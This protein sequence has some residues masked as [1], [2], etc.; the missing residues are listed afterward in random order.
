M[1]RLL[2]PV[3]R[4]FAVLL[5]SGLAIGAAVFS[6]QASSP[7]SSDACTVEQ[8]ALRTADGVLLD[9]LL[10]RPVATPR[11]SAILLVHGFGGNFYEA[12]FPLFGQTAREQGYTTLALNM[13]DHDAG[14]KV[15]S[16]IDNEIDIAAGLAY[17]RKLGYSRFVLLGQS[18]GTNRVLYFQAA[19]KDPTIAATILV[20]GPGN[21]FE[22]N[23]W[24]FGRKKAQASVDEALALQAAGRERDLML[25]DLGP[26]GK[27]L[28]TARYLLSLRGPEARSDPYQNIQKLKNPI[29]ILQGAA[30]KLIEPD[31]ATRLKRAASSSPKVDL[32]YIDG[33]GHSFGGQDTVIAQRILTWLEDVTP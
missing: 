13:R 20:S 32:I 15:S 28:Y 11:L 31:I 14:P 5:L 26:I 6:P 1:G 23:V 10:Y 21:L 33:A 9:G 19:S 8:V 27:A 4:F 18:V 30:D 12:Y 3:T 29:L 24:Q 7:A 22:W 25:V 16:F 17:L 2:K